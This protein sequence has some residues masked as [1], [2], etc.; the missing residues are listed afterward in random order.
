MQYRFVNKIKM[1]YQ[2]FYILL[3]PETEFANSYCNNNAVK[4]SE[5]F[6][7]EPVYEF[8]IKDTEQ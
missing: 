1:I 5:H 3:C 2:P 8:S 7:Y 6:I 4:S